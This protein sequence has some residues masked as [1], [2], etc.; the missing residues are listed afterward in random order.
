[1]A[2]FA[3]LLLCVLLAPAAAGA[4]PEDCEG[5]NPLHCGDEAKKEGTEARRHV[6]SDPDVRIAPPGGCAGRN[7]RYCRETEPEVE[8]AKAEPPRRKLR[9]PS[10]P[11]RNPNRN[12]STNPNRNPRRRGSE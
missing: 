4:E 9:S 11:S 8:E 6:E 5:R 10:R 7:P 1:V 2:R 12:P 3:G